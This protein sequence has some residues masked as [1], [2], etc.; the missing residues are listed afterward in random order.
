M[1]IDALIEEYKKLGIDQ[2]VDFEKI[3]LYSIIAHSTA[4]EGSTITVEE[5]QVL[6]DEGLAIKGKPLKDQMMNLDLKEAYLS[7]FDLAR[8]HLDILPET[9]RTLSGLVMRRTGGIFKT[10]NEDFD[11]SRGDFRLVNVTAGYGGRSYLSYTKVNERV[12]RFCE[13]LNEQRKELPH[14]APEE[15]YKLSFESHLRLV[16]IHPWVD[17]NGRMSRLL[18]NLIQYEA[19]VIQTIILKE[20]RPDYISALQRSQMEENKEH[21][22]RFMIQIQKRNLESDISK[23]LSSLNMDTDFSSS[24]EKVDVHSHKE[25][26]QLKPH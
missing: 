13:W 15:S 4:I 25:K 20:D 10:A 23:H 18:M 19:G 24:R 7:A 5:N 9:L 11:S 12:S 3:H 16:S 2:Q 17:G 1:T 21:F 26:T 14:L 8:K 6:L 22:I